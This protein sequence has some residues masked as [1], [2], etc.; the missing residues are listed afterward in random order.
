MNVIS[1]S[2][3]E[4]RYLLCESL[5]DTSLPQ[6]FH[7]FLRELLV[8]P[9]A[10]L[11]GVDPDIC[12]TR[13]ERRTRGRRKFVGREVVLGEILHVPA[14]FAPVVI[15]PY[16]KACANKPAIPVRVDTPLGAAP[17]N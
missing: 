15:H 13:A 8:R 7:I 14:H 3:F 16:S 11:L 9:P 6:R 5:F 12:V 10:R 17:P 1:D 4:T 2:A